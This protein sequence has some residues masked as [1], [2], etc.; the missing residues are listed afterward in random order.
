MLK[1]P[2][3]TVLNDKVNVDDKIKNIS[4]LNSVIYKRITHQGQVKFIPK[5]SG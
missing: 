3:E 1:E 4:K 2:R 5:M